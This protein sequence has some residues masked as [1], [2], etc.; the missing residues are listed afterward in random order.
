MNETVPFLQPIKPDAGPGSEGIP[1]ELIIGDLE[2]IKPGRSQL[3]L[4]QGSLLRRINPIQN[5]SL[6]T[7]EEDRSV[8]ATGH[9]YK[10]REA[11]W[12]PRSRQKEWAA[13]GAEYH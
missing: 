6:G 4:L 12:K 1:S 3:V 9:I 11:N 2:P 13:Q 5:A 8:A 7:S 10:K